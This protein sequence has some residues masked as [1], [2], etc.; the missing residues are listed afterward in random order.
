MGMG[1]DTAGMSQGKLKATGIRP[2][3]SDK[4]Q[5]QGIKLPADLFEP[6]PFARRSS[7]DNYSV[8]R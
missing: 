5:D 7:Q 4:L 8:V 1:F 3:F 6:E 2:S